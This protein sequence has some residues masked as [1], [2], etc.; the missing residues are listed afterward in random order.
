MVRKKKLKKTF[1][2]IFVLSL[3]CLIFSLLVI[4]IA[5]ITRTSKIYNPKYYE[6]KDY[7]RH[8]W[9]EKKIR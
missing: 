8:E 5:Y 3:I 4:Y 6:P 7:Q 1:K 9:L 2:R